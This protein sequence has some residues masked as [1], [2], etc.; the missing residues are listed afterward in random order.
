M[1]A[2][3]A[4]LTLLVPV[5]AVGAP[6]AP[7]PGSAASGVRDSHR[8]VVY[9]Q[10]H[11][12]DDRT[13]TGYISAL[14][15]L[16][17]GTGVDVVNLAAIHMNADVLHLNDDPPSDP[18]YDRMWAELHTMQAQGIAVV[19][20]I[21]GAQNDTWPSLQA[22]FATQ[23]ARLRDFVTTYGLDGVD[24][25]IELDEAQLQQGLSVDVGTVVDVIDALRADF[26]PDFLIT[27]SPV[28]DEFVSPDPEDPDADPD[29]DGRYGV[30][31]N[32]LYRQRGEEIDWFNL[33]AYCGHGDPTPEQYDEIVRY[34]HLRGADIPARK[35]VIAA[36]TAEENCTTG[37]WIP[38]EELTDGLRQ[39]A[40]T[41]PDLGGVAGWEYFNSQPG[42]TARPWEWAARMRDAL[43]GG[44]APPTTEPST[45]VPG[46]TEPG[47]TEP[48]TTE[49]GTTEPGTTDFPTTGTTS[50]PP[51]STRSDISTVSPAPVAAVALTSTPRSA[52][53]RAG[54]TAQPQQLAATGAG[55][56]P[57]AAAG[58][59]GILVGV[60]GLMAARRSRR[61]G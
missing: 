4:A 50:S 51:S 12:Q 18:M 54:A 48:G 46:T 24:L 28:A 61:A 16:T 6:D 23:Y 41:H 30:D 39:L 33:Q 32:E 19:G 26:G 1:I 11:F 52:T 56:L 34:Q 53:S 55:V 25:D 21:G 5:A 17:E 35:L 45:T 7:P 2:A 59:V 60:A 37:G 14:P 31:M 20:M 40:A 15:L 10:K 38:I 43:D 22:D 8:V 57:L 9:Y 44:Q 36:I 58:G 13:R 47:T 3:T 42:G 29:P 49:P 27:Y